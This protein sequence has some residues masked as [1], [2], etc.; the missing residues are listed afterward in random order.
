MDIVK[1]INL[2]YGY[3]GIAIFDLRLREIFGGKGKGQ[4]PQTNYARF[5]SRRETALIGRI[6]LESKLIGSLSPKLLFWKRD[7]D[8]LVSRH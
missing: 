8:A 2:W 4:Y 1:L 5:I 7:K 6:F 3:V